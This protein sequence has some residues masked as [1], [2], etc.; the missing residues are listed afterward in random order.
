M[1]KIAYIVVMWPVRFR[2]EKLNRNWKNRSEQ[3]FLKKANNFRFYIFH[4]LENWNPKLKP[5]FRDEKN[6]KTER[7]PKFLYSRITSSLQYTVITIMYMI[8]HMYKMMNMYINVLLM[9]LIRTVL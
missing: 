6:Q 1:T 3:R 9:Q 4:F 7:T 8:F 5:R 2:T